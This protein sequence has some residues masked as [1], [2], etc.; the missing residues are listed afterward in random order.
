MEQEELL[1]VSA[2]DGEGHPGVVALVTVDR[3]ETQDGG[4]GGAALR[5]PRE[6]GRQRRLGHV[7]VGVKHTHEHMHV[8]AAGH[9]GRVVRV[10]AQPV[11]V[12]GLMVEG[13]HRPQ[14][15]YNT[16]RSRWSTGQPNT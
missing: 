1:W 7:V 4:A 11:A 12:C 9:D 15:A 8:G 2:G 10:H 13:D 5:H 16:P 6:V 3:L 14:H